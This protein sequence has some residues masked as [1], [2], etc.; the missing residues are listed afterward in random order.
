[1]IEQ[2][3]GISR[4]RV[5]IVG[6]ILALLG[7]LLIIVTILHASSTVKL[8]ESKLNI[9]TEKNRVLLEQIINLERKITELES[10]NLDLYSQLNKAGNTVFLLEAIN[11]KNN[12]TMQVQKEKINNLQDTNIWLLFGCGAGGILGIGASI[13]TIFEYYQLQSVCQLRET[14]NNRSNALNNLNSSANYLI[15][16]LTKQKNTI[17]DLIANAN[18]QYNA[19][20]DTAHEISVQAEAVEQQSL[21]I[22]SV[23]IGPLLNVSQYVNNT[24]WMVIDDAVVNYGYPYNHYTILYDSNTDGFN[25]TEFLKR[26]TGQLNT[27]T[28]VFTDN[29]YVFGAGIFVAWSNQTGFITD[30]FAFTLSVNNGDICGINRNNTQKAVYISP[31]IMFQFGEGDIII[32][33]NKTGWAIA[34]ITYIPIYGYPGNVTNETFY[35]GTPNFNVTRIITRQAHNWDQGRKRTL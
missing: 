18:E 12:I 11:E 27:I 25:R 29:G 24:L 2:E 14:I 15:Q 28:I 19:I 33:E 30:K 8:Y 5:L 23:N 1:M 6:G 32:Y 13:T 31:E 7:T 35:A 16:N 17:N 10:K 20:A 22:W 21:A 3:S 26:V 9:Q 34:N 4:K